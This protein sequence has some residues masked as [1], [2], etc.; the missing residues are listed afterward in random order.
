MDKLL[1]V[2]GVSL[3]FGGLCALDGVSVDVQAG[4]ISGLIG[5]NGAGKTSLLNCISRLYR[6]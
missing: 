4:A 6:P 5:P 2:Q 1:S 3:F